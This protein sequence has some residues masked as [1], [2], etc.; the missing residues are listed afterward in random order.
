MNICTICTHEISRRLHVSRR[1]IHQTIRKFDK[2]HTVATKPGAGRPRKGTERQ[3]R[4]IKLQQLRDDTYSLT[5]LVRYSY[6]DL[7]LSISRSTV[8]RILRD[9]NMISYIVPRKPRI[10]PVQRRNRVQ[11]CY[12]HLSW[13]AT[14]WSNVIF[15]DESNYEI[16]NRTNRIYIRRF[17]HD[18]TRFYRSQ[19]R[20]HKGGGIPAHTLKLDCI[21]IHDR[22]YTSIEQSQ[23]FQ[24]ASKRNIIKNIILNETCTLEKVKILVA[25]CPR[26][27]DLNIEIDRK[28]LASIIRFSPLML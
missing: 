15:S 10:T 4:L 17:R 7:N 20:V 27:E 28:N 26:L 25:L 14:D 12:E 8:S 1:C 5:D 19:Q 24:Y 3:R 23:S 21:S 18:S 9:F 6:T 2:F 16:F 13:S 11:W 22:E